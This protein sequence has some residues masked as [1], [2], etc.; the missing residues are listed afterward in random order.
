MRISRLV[1]TA[2]TFSICMQANAESVTAPVA[3]YSTA[4]EAISIGVDDIAGVDVELDG[5]SS[6]LYLSLDQDARQ[7]L[8]QLTGNNLGRE[9]SFAVCEEE[10]IRP[11]V[12]IPV[13]SGLTQL[14]L[15]EA[16]ALAISEVLRGQLSCSDYLQ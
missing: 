10:L 7:A 1:L 6:T 3:R 5:E 9:M 8:D 14:K 11:I 12:N 15:T 13:T 16:K 4:S 2:S